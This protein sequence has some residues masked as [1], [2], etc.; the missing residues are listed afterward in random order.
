MFCRKCGT[1]MPDDSQFCM[2]CGQA[3]SVTSTAGGAAA[4][5]APARIPTPVEAP[6]Q[7]HSFG[8]G[9]LVLSVLLLLL[10][11]VWGVEQANIHSPLP[12]QSASIQQP[13]LQQHK[14]STGSVAFTANAGGM[15]N[16]KF[17]VPAGASN[18]TVKGHFAATGG[19]GNDIQVV[20]VSEDEYVNWQN[21]HPTKTF[22]NSGRV[23]QD[24]VN[25]NLPSDAATYY[26]L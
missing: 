1:N 4:A 16:Y 10:V 24:A 15:T 22:Y 5:A 7:K 11:I 12:A 2:K 6:Q 8:V 19:S 3:Q 25:I 20:V 21:G 13:P 9:A 14:Q 23:T 18:V 26:V 17:T